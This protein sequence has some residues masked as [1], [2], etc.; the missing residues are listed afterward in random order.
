MVERLTYHS[1]LG[2]GDHCCMKF[3]LNCYANTH[4]IKEGNI[5][6]YNYYR[7]DYT[8]I[9]RRLGNI[10]W[11]TMLNGIIKEDYRKF[12]E[13]LHLAT[14]GCI[15]NRIFSR[16]KK[17]MY[18]TTYSLRLKNRKHLLWKRYINTKSSYDHSKID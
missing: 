16:K 11:E 13:Q 14:V 9:K 12:I 7:A 5:L 18:M 17:N 6:L 3:K 15:P 2:D 1:A 8:T 4:K 10:D